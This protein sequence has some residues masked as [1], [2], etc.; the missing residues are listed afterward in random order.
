MEQCLGAVSRILGW[1]TDALAHDTGDGEHAEGPPPAGGSKPD[2][3]L[4][5]RRGRLASWQPPS[6]AL[7]GD[8]GRASSS[9][10]L[11]KFRWIS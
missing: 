2:P 9:K 11:A 8:C 4:S 7:E 1:T 10:F 5:S 6:S 3:L